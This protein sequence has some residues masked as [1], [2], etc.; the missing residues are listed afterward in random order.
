M[1]THPLQEEDGYELWLRY[2]RVEDAERLAQYRQ[3]I[4]S[5]AVLGEGATIDVTRQEL[6]RALPVLLDC[7]IPIV[8]DIPSGSALIV[9]TL[10]ECR[11]VGITVPT[12][13]DTP[14]GSETYW[15]H[16]EKAHGHTVVA[17]STPIATLTGAFHLLR[18]LQTWQDIDRLTVASSPKIKLRILGHWDNLDGSIERGY[19]GKS[20]WRWDELPGK[21]DPR[22]QDYARACASIGINGCNLNNV[23]ANPKSLTGEYLQKA[24]ALADVFRPYGIHIYLSPVFSAPIQLGGLHTADPRH[25]A[26]AAWWQQKVAEIYRLIPDF[27]GFQV[28]A[29]SEGQPGPQDYG[30]NHHDGANLL[31]GALRPYGGTLLWRAFVYDTRVDDDRAKCAYKEFVPLDRQFDENVMV[32]TKNGAI[33]YQPREPF[34]PLFGALEQ[35]PLALELQVTQE[36]FGQS[37]HLVYLGEMWQEV[38]EADTYCRGAG[39][40]VARVIDGS[41]HGHDRSCVVAV[42][43]TGSDRNWCGHHFSQANWYAYGRL[44]W[45]HQASAADIAEEWI[46]MTWSNQAGVVETL[47]TL[48]LASWPACI[49]YMTPLGLHHLMQEGHHYGPDPGFD[50]A[51]RKDWNN[52]YYHRADSQGIGFDRSSRGS[53]AT[54]Q[55]HSPLCEQ[56]DD[57]RTCPEKYLLWFHHAPWHHRMASG[58]TLWEEM[59][60]RYRS[61]VAFVEEMQRTWQTLSGQIDPQRHAHVSQRLAQ[62]L[63]NARQWCTVCSEYFR[64]FAGS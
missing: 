10:G 5:I 59:Q 60:Q 57:I 50:S 62:Q 21:I 40:T 49:D 8:N 24:A 41:L 38:L 43:N 45:D 61:G 19:A 6:A 64:R 44:A 29:N 18:L 58:K 34:H 2:R 53:N 56:F 26:V 55:Y 30:A 28:K 20:L 35:T 39:S 36:Y 11:R 46:R 1:H 32:L 63:E 12:A 33:D 14:P 15:L 42:A 48:M 51:P 22:Y 27:G 13:A 4:G 47:K 9:G 17:G 3:A 54:G 25:P 31:A 37:I 52:V 16:A 23:N 7:K